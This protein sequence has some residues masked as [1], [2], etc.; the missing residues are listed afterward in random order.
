MSENSKQYTGFVTARGRYEYNRLPF[1]ILKQPAIW[2]QLIDAQLSG[3]RWNFVITYFD[4]ILAYS[5]GANARAHLDHLAQIFNRLRNAGI[6]LSA[7]KTLLCREELLYLGHVVISRGI[8]P[9]PAKAAAIADIPW[10]KLKTVKDVRSFL[11]MCSYY[12]RY[13]PEF[14][15]ISAPLRDIANGSKVPSEPSQE[16]LDSFQKL[17]N[18]LTLPSILCYPD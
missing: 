16:V 1:G 5:K 14:A 4:D 10:S 12:R 6:K 7:K 2:C 18:Y 15:R 9:D 13:V 3:L 11:Q 8:R 17:K